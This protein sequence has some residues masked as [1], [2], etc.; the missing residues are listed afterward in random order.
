MQGRT[1]GD[2]TSRHAMVWLSG[3]RVQ[4]SGVLGVM[5]KQRAAPHPG[6]PWFGLIGTGHSAKGCQGWWG[7]EG[8]HCIWASHGL[9]KILLSAPESLVLPRVQ[10]SQSTT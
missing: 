6:M 1:K 8:Q 9:A 10:P 7:D 3:D 2:A 5:G 4:H